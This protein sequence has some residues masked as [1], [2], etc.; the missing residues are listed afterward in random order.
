MSVR[1]SSLRAEIQEALEAPEQTEEDGFSASER[2]IL[3]NVLSWAT[4]ASRT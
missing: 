2:A 3:Q 4:C 1:S